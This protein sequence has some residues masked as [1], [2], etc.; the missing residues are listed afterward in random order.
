MSEL[1][2]VRSWE[3]HALTMALL[4][5]LPTLLRGRF[6]R[7]HS[8]IGRLIGPSTLIGPKRVNGSILIV[9]LPCVCMHSST[10][11]A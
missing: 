6:V 11:S 9:C 5:L 3:T 7:P 1:Y 2:S 4:V 10:V 8:L